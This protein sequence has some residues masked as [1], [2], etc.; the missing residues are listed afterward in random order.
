MLYEYE[1][2][3]CW[4]RTQEVHAIADRH[5]KAPECCGERMKLIITSAPY[6]YMDRKIDYICPVTNEHVTS[7]RQRRNIMAREGLVSAHELMSSKAE[8]EKKQRKVDDMREKRFGPQ[9]VQDQVNDWARRQI[10]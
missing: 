7:K 6:G 8:R 2:K 3:H 5:D 9:Q 4:R 10:S 1:C